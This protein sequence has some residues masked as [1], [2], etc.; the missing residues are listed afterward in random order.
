MVTDDMAGTP[1]A[2]LHA[3]TFRPGLFRQLLDDLRRQ[4]A[5]ALDGQRSSTVNQPTL[6]PRCRSP[7]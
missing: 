1:R 3:T 7:R 2:F 5:A 6:R 4:H